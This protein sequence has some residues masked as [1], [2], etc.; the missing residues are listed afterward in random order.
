MNKSSWFD[1]D[2]SFFKLRVVQITFCIIV[3][4]STIIAGAIIIHGN[5]TRCFT[6]TCFNT[7][8]STFSVSLGILSTLIPIIAV[9][10]ANHRSEQTKKQIFLSREQN[11]FTN[12]YKHLEEFTSY[13][14]KL[15]KEKTRKGLTLSNIRDV[16]KG[17]FPKAMEGELHISNENNEILDK[18][19]QTGISV[20]ER[21]TIIQP[22]GDTKYSREEICNLCDAL[23]I[24]ANKIKSNFNLD[25]SVLKEDVLQKHWEIIQANMSTIEFEQS[26]L[27]LDPFFQPFST[28]AELYKDILNFIPI[29]TEIP[30]ALIYFQKYNYNSN[31]KLLCSNKEPFNIKLKM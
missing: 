6:A 15:E 21:L 2:T 25:L 11:N 12:Y 16:H 20:M 30:R 13:F 17:F 1:P 29:K 9:Y 24:Q 23:I 28:F 3:I 31:S 27:N 19:Y 26:A 10:S 18:A 7:F 22:Q 5:Y 14:K 4:I 8:V